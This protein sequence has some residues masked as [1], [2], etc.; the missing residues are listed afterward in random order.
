MHTYTIIRSHYNKSKG[1]RPLYSNQPLVD[2]EDPARHS[3]IGLAKSVGRFEEKLYC[4][5]DNSSRGIA[6]S[7]A[8]FSTAPSS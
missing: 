8:C 7:A 2:A 4:S 5:M 3:G 6:A 1:L